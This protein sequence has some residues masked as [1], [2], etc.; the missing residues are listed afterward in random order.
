MMGLVD[1]RGN[2]SLGNETSGRVG[3]MSGG[4]S[5]FRRSG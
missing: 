1:G 5:V 2:G 4:G 3:S